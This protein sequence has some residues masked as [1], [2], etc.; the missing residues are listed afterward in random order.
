MNTQNHKHFKMER[1]Q[2]VTH[3][4]DLAHEA[5]GGKTLDEMRRAEAEY[6]N[7]R[8]QAGAATSPEAAEALQKYWQGVFAE[9]PAQVSLLM[10]TRRTAQEMDYDEARRKFWAILQMRAAHIAINSRNPEFKW[11][12]TEEEAA[13][14]ANLLRYFINDPS[15]QYPLTKGLFVYGAP[16]TGK[17]EI[18]QAL[19]RF[20]QEYDLTKKFEFVSMSAVYDRARKGADEV[21]TQEQQDRCF[22]EFGRITGTVLQYGNPI[23]LNE[24]VL[25]ARYI[26]HQRY[27]QITHLVTNTTPNATKQMFTPALYDRIRVMCTG[28]LFSGASKRQ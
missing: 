18:M 25:E 1:K 26:R 7:K 13:Q 5:A 22:D 15:G 24:S 3:I 11:I 20:T 12:F 14:I 23:D 9:K 4:G 6:L 17:T 28:V 10:V 2:Q 8:L 27:G 16:G 19:S 21:S